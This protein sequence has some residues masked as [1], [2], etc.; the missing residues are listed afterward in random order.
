MAANAAIAAVNDQQHVVVK[1]NSA[2]RQLLFDEMKRLKF[3]G[4]AS[5]ANL[6]MINIRTP[7]PPV[8]Q[9]FEKRKVWWV[10]NSPVCRRFSA[11]RSA[12][13]TR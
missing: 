5:Q 11:S 8:I 1:L 10:A 13:P 9:E 12:P 3:A 4:T 6:A 2:Q 7:V